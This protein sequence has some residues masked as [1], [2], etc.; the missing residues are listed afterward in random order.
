[1]GY[2]WRQNRIW[3]LLVIVNAIF[4]VF[5]EN[6]KFWF[7]RYQRVK[8]TYFTSILKAKNLKFLIVHNS[9][10]F[11]QYQTIVLS[12]GSGCVEKHKYFN[13]WSKGCRF[14]NFQRGLKFM[15]LEFYHTLSDFKASISE[16]SVNL[17]SKFMHWLLS[18]SIQNLIP[19]K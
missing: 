2:F 14:C 8:K 12:I 15:E 7:L 5:T 13:I 4:G 19:I 3:A 11:Q 6:E 17:C 18:K 10:W 16:K 1:M 9:R